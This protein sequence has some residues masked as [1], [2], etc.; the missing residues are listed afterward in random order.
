[1]RILVTSWGKKQAIGQLRQLLAIK[2]QMDLSTDHRLAVR[3]IPEVTLELFNELLDREKVNWAMEYQFNGINQIEEDE[4]I[5]ENSQ[6]EE[7]LV[8][9]Y[10]DSE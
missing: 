5:S 1:M 10:D 3:I 8:E 6:E 4:E 2:P 7:E 9:Y